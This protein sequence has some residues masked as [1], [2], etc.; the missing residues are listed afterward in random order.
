MYYSISRKQIKEL[1]Y[2]CC[3]QENTRWMARSIQYW[4]GTVPILFHW[5][6]QLSHFCQSTRRKIK[7]ITDEQK[8]TSDVITPMRKMTTGLL[9]KKITSE[10]SRLPSMK[11]S[12]AVDFPLWRSFLCNISCTTVLQHLRIQNLNHWNL[13]IEESWQTYLYTISELEGTAL[14]YLSL[15]Q[16][17]LLQGQQT[18]Q[19]G[20]N[21][22]KETGKCICCQ[23]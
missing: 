9:L 20:H 2:L 21:R 22:Q 7:S 18:P 17:L 16:T 19:H 23:D 10:T 13:S 4:D 8:E 11:L 15:R 5:A 1:D 14:A 12:N 3:N 6:R